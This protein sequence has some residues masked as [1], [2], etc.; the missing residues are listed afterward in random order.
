[1]VCSVVFLNILEIYDSHYWSCDY[2][3]GKVCSVVCVHF[4]CCKLILC[5][6]LG[7]FRAFSGCHNIR[8]EV[9]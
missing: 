8:V 6:H 2:F 7:R 1:M 5:V 3:G 4:L 9:N